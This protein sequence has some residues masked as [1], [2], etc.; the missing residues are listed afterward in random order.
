MLFVFNSLQELTVQVLISFSPKYTLYWICSVILTRLSP[1]A[2]YNLAMYVLYF[3]MALSQRN[4]SHDFM[5]V[6]MCWILPFF[7]EKITACQY[8][9][10]KECV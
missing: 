10:F 1:R 5:T 4:I 6:R 9:P 8:V 2:M 7:R 3:M